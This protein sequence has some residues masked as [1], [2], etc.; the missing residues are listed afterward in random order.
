[1]LRCVRILMKI[2]Q[3]LI[4]ILLLI[5]C[6]KSV[7]ITDLHYIDR[8]EMQLADKVEMLVIE[9]GRIGAIHCNTE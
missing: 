9:T 8:P 1:M 4:W 6:S 7:L 5:Q 3:K 2:F